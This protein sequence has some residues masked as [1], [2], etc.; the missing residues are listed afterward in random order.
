MNVN[1]AVALCRVA[2]LEWH[3]HLANLR[4][5]RNGS[6]ITWSNERD[7]M[8]PAVPRRSDVFRL[9]RRGQY[10]FQ[11]ANDGALIQVQYEYESGSGRLRKARLAYYW[12]RAA[13]VVMEDE[14]D[15]TDA[16]DAGFTEANEEEDASSA[17]KDSPAV[18]WLRI[19]YDPAAAKGPIHAACHLQLVGF[20]DS[21]LIV[22]GVPTPTQFV[23]FIMAACYPALY[24]AHRLAENGQFRDVSRVRAMNNS[25]LPRI[26]AE[27]FP[28][29]T[30]L[31]IPP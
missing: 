2:Y 19:D 22:D 4:S 31:R 29:I 14:I 25:C 20:P 21:R 17:V 8:I 16:P 24:R 10:S 1:E 27:A 11:V 23:E 7:I 28:H 13:K 5:V 6:R 18:R 3:P 9:A 15:S 26:P 12:A 30:H